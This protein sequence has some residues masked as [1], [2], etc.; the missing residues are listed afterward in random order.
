MKRVGKARKVKKVKVTVFV[1][2]IEE[3][4]KLAAR[5]GVT[6]KKMLEDIVHKYAND[7]LFLEPIRKSARHK[8]K[9]Q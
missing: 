7:E 8:R 6:L 4:K 1:T 9:K 2:R 3:Y 5:Q